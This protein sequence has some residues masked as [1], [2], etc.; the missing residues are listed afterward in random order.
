MEVAA[1]NRVNAKTGIR[2]LECIAKSV[3]ATASCVM[4]GLIFVLN[5]IVGCICIMELA[6][7][8]ALVGLV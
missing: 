7:V 3:T 1:L 2:K 5:A 8:V 6:L 4:E